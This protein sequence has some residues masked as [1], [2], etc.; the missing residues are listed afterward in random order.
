[1]TISRINP[2]RILVVD[3]EPFVCES[4]RML[5]SFE[6]HSVTTAHTA[7]EAL[8]IFSPQEFDVLI[9]D[10]AMPGMQGSELAA[11]IR[12]Q[13]PGLPVLLVTAYADMLDSWGA[14][15]SSV[16]CVVSKPF[17]LEGLRKAL[18]DAVTGTARL[19]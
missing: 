13:A 5:L 3:D 2:S 9:T 12:E 19:H 17:R 15:L 14:D 8:R 18:A 4:I 7:E 10:Y 16:D 11:E 1:M 6:G